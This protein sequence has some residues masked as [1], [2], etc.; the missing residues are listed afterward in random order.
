MARDIE[1]VTAP[2][3]NSNPFGLLSLLGLQNGGRNPE[4]MPNVLQPTIDLLDWYLEQEPET[5]TI[6]AIGVAAV[7]N[8]DVLAGSLRVPNNE[9]WYVTGYTLRS[10]ALTAGQSFGMLAVWQPAGVTG[11]NALASPTV[12][13]TTVG[14]LVHTETLG[15]FWAGPGSAFAG[16]CTLLAAGPVNVAGCVT[17]K[18]LRV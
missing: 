18:R 17:F 5:T 8:F 2:R 16:V 9:L 15:G 10:A 6:A 4:W 7:G 14:E 3:I 1:P 12:R 13:S 11:Q